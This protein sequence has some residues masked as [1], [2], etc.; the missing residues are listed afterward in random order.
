[1]IQSDSYRVCPQ[2]QYAGDALR[3]IQLVKDQAAANSPDNQDAKSAD[4]IFGSDASSWR[5]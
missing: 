3:E 1:M 4:S 5:S 2:V